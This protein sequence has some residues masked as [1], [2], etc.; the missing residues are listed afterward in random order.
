[1]QKAA[2]GIVFDASKTK[3]LLIKR[4]DV[5]IWVLPGGGIDSLELPIDAA[6]R[7]VKEET[8][9]DCKAV[10]HIALYTTKG[11]L[12]ANTYLYELERLSAD[13]NLK[14][15]EE[16]SDLGYFAIDALPDPFFSVHK[17]WIQDALLN[18][19]EPII[20]PLEGVSFKTVFLFA[21]KNPA[22]FFRYVISRMGL[23]INR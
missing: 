22:L 13:N 11:S 12:T 18:Q 19:K 17:L 21:I 16:T 3:I 6:V 15:N 9:L 4:R 7:E 14:T 10:R 1:M 23:P 2:F 5:P 8:G 20:K